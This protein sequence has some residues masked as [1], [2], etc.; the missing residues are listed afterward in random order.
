MNTTKIDLLIDDKVPEIVDP[1]VPIDAESNSEVLTEVIMDDFHSLNTRIHALNL[2]YNLVGDHAIDLVRNLS[3][4]YQL[5]G[6]SNLSN[7]LYKICT[8]STVSPVIK[9]EA[10]SS[11]LMY[12]ESEQG[13]D[14]DDDDE[15]AE[16]QRKNDN[17]IRTR[18]LSR[19]KIGY[20]ALDYVCYDLNKMP[21]PRR[22][23]AIFLLMKSPDYDKNTEA[24]FREFIRDDQV[25]CE[26]RYKTIISLEHTCRDEMTRTIMSKFSDKN[27]LSEI[28]KNYSHEISRLYPGFNPSHQNQVF[29]GSLMT[30]F[31]YD[32]IR[33]IH[34]RYF[35]ENRPR[36]E[37]FIDKA[38]YTFLFH[39]KNMT[40]YR[41]LAG[42]YLLSKGNLNETMVFKIENEL[43]KFAKDN[44]LDYNRR[45][46]AA[47]VLLKL[48]SVSMKQHG[49]D[50]IKELGRIGGIVRS[51]FD[52]AQNVHNEEVESSVAE[53]LEYLASLQMMQHDGAPITFEYVNNCIEKIMQEE[54]ESMR[55]DGNSEDSCD[56]CGS[57]ITEK[58][59]L[60]KNVFCSPECLRYF[61]RDEK[62]RISLNRIYLDRVRYSKFNNTLVAILLKIWTFINGHS[63]EN[64]LIKR[65]LEELEEMSGTCSSG[66][67]SRMINVLAG[68]SDY[69]IRI[70]WEDQISGNF[71]GRLNAAARKITDPNSVFY[72]DRLN[73]VVSL[74]LDRPEN[75][76]IK[77][78]LCKTLNPK[79]SREIVDIYLVD[80][81]Q[82]KV[83]KCVQDFAESVINEMM[84]PSSQYDNRMNFSLFFRTKAPAIQLEITNE[85][86]GLLTPTDID[87]YLRKAL[88]NYDGC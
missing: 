62:I 32:R 51:V 26:Y 71:S 55:I 76:Q 69:S 53:A 61:Y 6:V 23:E 42:Q 5:S 59:S 78:T 79:S 16:N 24:Y 60:D 44:D 86:S 49:R 17:T 57:P 41:T 7:F 21:T 52:D 11:L 35:P 87:L 19:K 45:A 72:T 37:Y 15:Q 1:D 50:V 70:S 75:I 30:Y 29:F 81:R 74:W 2:Y 22:V 68:Y 56:H 3:S 27:M 9:L 64:E 25:E 10:A 58:I 36:W 31:S 46:D 48:G 39:E 67:A 34:T 40:F 14:S 80:N 33:E 28:Y 12:E 66:Y 47:D 8:H 83:E 85:F 88:M 65:L 18:N 43:L 20:S 63:S 77:R 82:E 73:D 54:R 38:M 4:M 13:P 84:V